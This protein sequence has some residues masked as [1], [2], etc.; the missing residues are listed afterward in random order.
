[1]P[2]GSNIVTGKTPNWRDGYVPPAAEWNAWWAQ[3]L[4]ASD[5]F[6]TQGPYLRLAG[7]IM[8]GRL[9][10]NVPPLNPMDAVTKAYTDAADSLLTTTKVNKAGDTMTGPLSLPFDPYQPLH[11]ATKQYV[12]NADALKVYR[13]GDTMTG[14]LTLAGDPVSG[15]QAATKQYVDGFVQPGAP[16]L[17]LSGG[18]MTG[19]LTLNGNPVSP[20]QAA[21]KGYVDAAVSTIYTL[22]GGWNASTNSPTLSNGGGGGVKGDVYTVSTAGSTSLDGQS[23]WAVGDQVQNTGTTW[24]RVAYSTS[25]GSMAFQQATAVAITGGT[26]AGVTSLG[27]SDSSVIQPNAS[28]PDLAWWRRDTSGNIV[29]ALDYAGV[30]K[31]Q[32]LQIY[33]QTTLGAF[34][35]TSGTVTTGTISTLNF[36]TATLPDSSVLQQGNLAMPDLAR[37]WRDPAGNIPVA[38]GTDGTLIAQNLRVIGTATLPGGSSGGG[39]ATVTPADTLDITKYGAVGDGNDDV[40]YGTWTNGGNT[41][42]LS[43][44]TGNVVWS[45]TAN[46][47]TL[48]DLPNTSSPGID[49][50]QVGK[51]LYI[52]ATDGSGITATIKITGWTSNSVVSVDTNA[53]GA[54]TTALVSWPAF[55]ASDLNKAIRVGGGNASLVRGAWNSGIWPYGGIIAS[56]LA[57]NQVTV[58]NPIAPNF[59]T[60]A[61][62]QPV[63]VSWG[64]DNSP[65][66]LAAQPDIIAKGIKYLW[67]PRVD[68]QARTVYCAFA[69]A[70]RHFGDNYF[71]NAFTDAPRTYMQTQW[72]GDPSVTGVLTDTSARLLGKRII[73]ARSPPPRQPMRDVIARLHMPRVVA[74][75]G[76][77]QVVEAGDSL[78]KYDPTA[79][80]DAWNPV[81]V[82][83]GL[84]RKQNP[85]KGFNFQNIANAGAGWAELVDPGSGLAWK[86]AGTD[87]YF[88]SSSG[89]NDFWRGHAIKVQ[90]GINLA[91]S[92]GNDG[93]GRAP[94]VLLT[95]AKV[96]T[97]S[98]PTQSAA[99]NF[100]GCTHTEVLVRTMARTQGF[101]CVDLQSYSEQAVFGASNYHRE[102][103]QLPE[104]N[105][106]SLTPA[107]PFTCYIDCYSW[108]IGVVMSAASAV[109]PLIGSFRVPLSPMPGN[110]FIIDYDTTANVLRYEA[111][112]WGREVATTVT[113]SGSTLST[114]AGTATTGTLTWPAFQNAIT[115]FTGG[116]FT[117]TTG[118]CVLL[119]G[120]DV[121]GQAQRTYVNSVVSDTV[122]VFDDFWQGNAPGSGNQT[123]ASS[124]TL[125]IGGQMFLPV[126]VDAATDIVMKWGT[127]EYRGKIT[128]FTS[129]NTVTVSPAPPALTNQAVTMWLGRISVPRTNTVQSSNGTS[130]TLLL[131][132]NRD[133]FSFRN[134]LTSCLFRGP[135]ERYGVRYAPRFRIT[136]TGPVTA[137]FT[138][139]YGDRDV[140]FTPVGTPMDIQSGDANASGGG[141]GFHDSSLTSERINRL[142]YE[143]LDLCAM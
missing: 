140:F 44:Y 48:S 26:L 64:T 10:L 9:V 6:V 81:G 128:G 138:D 74:V 42:T 92:S 55:R 94:D 2:D 58:T 91:R 69:V 17:S 37:W 129:N 70:Q 141:G 123:F 85:R 112:L 8:L 125:T 13:T 96:N 62:A 1:M 122:A 142:A 99:W 39:G 77:V 23:T 63:R 66:Y 65:A 35:A 127:S 107:N 116:G 24:V 102:L 68:G 47:L 28:M 118:Q 114:T 73:P 78:A 19:F 50:N 133:E 3:K 90:A 67:H 86:I 46:T 121:N 52:Q 53:P 34:T 130:T 109:W 51:Y 132:F 88:L 143:A 98:L 108:S 135:V 45:T 71:A 93:G 113:T 43:R 111:R 59:S 38:I 76:T 105:G 131:S 54:V 11:A 104:V 25:F 12:D 15:L 82:W 72:I 18:T 79:Q 120:L 139:I 89:I 106:W 137:N 101:G 49:P 36:T 87:L 40:F 117:G 32:A 136:G 33:G 100:D 30:S 80:S 5:P 115:S 56:V 97:Q 126:D 110:E 119:P 14:P 57:G 61:S 95:T 41:L 84:M 124:V 22:R 16:F 103:Q 60:A 83:E 27:F 20:L 134:S 29:Q 7:G 31:F 4:D 21:T 75:A